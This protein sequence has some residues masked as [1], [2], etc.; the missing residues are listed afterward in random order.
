M[1][2]CHKTADRLC[3]S[4]CW[5]AVADWCWWSVCPFSACRL[6][7][8]LLNGLPLVSWRQTTFFHVPVGVSENSYDRNSDTACLVWY[9]NGCRWATGDTAGTAGHLS[10]FRQLWPL[11]ASGSP[12][13]WCCTVW[14]STWLGAVIS[15]WQ[16]QQIAYSDQISVVQPVLFGVLDPVV[17]LCVYTAELGLA[18]ARDGLNLHQYADDTQVYV[19]TSA[20][21]ASWATAVAIGCLA[22]Y[23]VDIEAWLKASQLRL[24]PHQ[25]SGYVVGFPIAAEVPVASTRINVS[26]TARDLVVVIDSKLSCLRGGHLGI[27]HY[28]LLFHS[29]MI[30]MDSLTPKPI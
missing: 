17:S 15:D 30:S 22:A 5:S 23:L 7:R 27:H 13:V 29:E 12:M 4:Y 6:F 25:D 16:T 21:D 28:P 14:F 24:K 11:H 8:R 19:N 20:K 3:R 26:E 9:T 2:D 1:Y 10:S 18:V